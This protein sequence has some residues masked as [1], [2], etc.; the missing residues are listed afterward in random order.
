METSVQTRTAQVTTETVETYDI[1]V[2]AI[3]GNNE[4]KGKFVQ[5][6]ANKDNVQ[7]QIWMNNQKLAKFDIKPGSVI[8]FEAS[9]VALANAYDNVAKADMLDENGETYPAPLVDGY[10]D[11]ETGEF[12]TYQYKRGMLDI[13]AKVV[14]VDNSKARPSVPKKSFNPL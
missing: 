9:S 1:P 3:Q 13:S 8:K 7:Y 11:A 10:Y 5:F 2:A 12:I 6:V 4:S 14:A